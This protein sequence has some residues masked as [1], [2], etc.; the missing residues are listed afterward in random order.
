MYAAAAH[1]PRAY[2][3]GAYAS[4]C[5]HQGVCIRAYASGRMYPG[6]VHPGRVHQSSRLEE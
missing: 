3:S 5:M 2:V 1:I 4:V 6:R